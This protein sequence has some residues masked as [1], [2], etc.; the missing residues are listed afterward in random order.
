LISIAAEASKYD[1]HKPDF[2]K[3]TDSPGSGFIARLVTMTKSQTRSKADVLQSDPPP[4]IIEELARYRGLARQNLDPTLAAF[5]DELKTLDHWVL[6]RFEARQNKSGVWKITKVPHQVIRNGVRRE[7]RSNDPK[8]WSTLAEAQRTLAESEGFLDGLGFM[9]QGSG[10]SGIDLDGVLVEG[11]DVVPWA[12]ELL[13][14]LRKTYVERS[15]RGEGLHGIVRGVFR[16]GGKSQKFADGTGFELYCTGRFFVVSGK[17]YNGAS[18]VIADFDAQRLYDR[19]ARGEI[20]PEEFRQQQ[21][22]EACKRADGPKRVVDVAAYLEAHDVEINGEPYEEV[23]FTRFNITCPGCGAK[24]AWILQHNDGGVSMGCYHDSCPF[25]NKRGDH[26]NDFKKLCELG[27]PAAAES[28]SEAKEGNGTSSSAQSTYVTESSQLAYA[29]RG[30]ALQ[31]GVA[32]FDKRRNITLLIHDYLAS[33]GEYFHTPDGRGFFFHK[34]ERRIYDIYSEA[35]ERLVASASGLSLTETFFK[36]A[37]DQSRTHAL[38]HSPTS[39][40]H[41]LAHYSPDSGTMAVS[42]GGSGIWIREKGGRWQ[43][44]HNGDGGIFFAVDDDA[45]PWQPAFDSREALRWFLDQLLFANHELSVEDSKT[46][47]LVWLLQQFFPELRRTRLVPCFLG[48]QGSGKSTAARLIGR[49]LVGPRFDVTGIRGDKEDAFVAAVTN[50]VVLGLD[51]ADSRIPWLPDALATY[52][53]GQRY[54]MRKLYTTNEELA[55]T[56]RAILL[57]SSR[58]PRFNRADVVERLLPLH[59]ERPALYRPEP[60]IFGE[61]ELHRGAIMGALL[62]HLGEITDAV[63]ACAAKSL[64]FRMADFASFG[65][66]IFAARGTSSQFL[67]LLARLEKTQSQFAAEADG[68]VEVL[69]FLLEQEPIENISVGDLFRKCRKIAEDNG[70]LIARSAQG[71]GRHLSNMQRVIEIELQV[72]PVVVIGHAGSR[73]ISLVAVGDSKPTPDPTPAEE[74]HGTA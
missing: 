3:L 14:E 44:L 55:Y 7:A 11:G 32:A 4:K 42:D 40:V 64:P 2:T 73:R 8:T 72:H 20:G 52:A 1:H 19:F 36:F 15:I 71:F 26:W 70:L 50:R 65:E 39:A 13:T 23:N 53:T 61:L 48:P 30:I 74:S 31:R 66:R 25:S 21:A 37:I 38:R 43:E 28:H 10:F 49:L 17:P 6:W 62:V 47:A 18:S 59:F 58:D 54:R 56:P 24:N 69:R 34:P 45:T 29:I 67:A 12:D 57:I 51:N 68:L 16:G 22:A 27:Q 41:T 5:P 60:E 35:F 9:F 46:L 33:I 63:A